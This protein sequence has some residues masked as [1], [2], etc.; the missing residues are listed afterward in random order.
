MCKKV[1][2]YIFNNKKL[3]FL[4][5]EEVYSFDKID[6]LLMLIFLALF[7]LM[8]FIKDKAY[9][10]IPL[11]GILAIVGIIRSIKSIPGDIESNFFKTSLCTQLIF[12]ILFTLISLSFII[13]K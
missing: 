2:L 5:K 7:I 10:L 4:K 8:H 11:F 1:L 9:I 13:T 3:D 12:F 6:K